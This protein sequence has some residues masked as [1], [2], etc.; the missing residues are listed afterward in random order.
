MLKSVPHPEKVLEKFLPGCATTYQRSKL[1]LAH[2][3][4]T[5]YVASG[6]TDFRSTALEAVAVEAGLPM[7]TFQHTSGP[8]YALVVA[9]RKYSAAVESPHEGHP[10]ATLSRLLS[11]GSQRRDRQFNL[12]RLNDFLSERHASGE[13]DFSMSALVKAWENQSPDRAY[14]AVPRTDYRVLI[15]AWSIYNSPGRA[16]RIKPTLSTVKKSIDLEWA[17][18]KYPHLEEWRALASRWLSTRTSGLGLAISAIRKLFDSYLSAFETA[19][20][21]A[22]LLARGTAIPPIDLSS[23]AAK[24]RKDYLRVHKEFIDW[25]LL[26]QFALEDDFDVPVVSPAFWNPFA[27]AL[28]SSAS[29]PALTESVLSPLAYP[30]IEELRTLLCEGPT[31]KDWKFAQTV[32][33][34]LPGSTGRPGSDWFEVP[35]E[36]IRPDDPD[37]VWRE[38]TLNG[39]QIYEM[40]EPVR[41]VALLVKLIIPLRTMQVR[42]LDSGET[43]ALRFTGDGWEKN[44]HHLAGPNSQGVFQRPNKQDGNSSCVLYVNTNKTADDAEV[45]SAKGYRLPWHQ[46]EEI[47]ENVHYWL[48]KLRDWQEKYNP[49]ERAIPWSELENRHIPAKSDAQLSRFLPTCFLFRSPTD[50]TSPYFPITDS[51]VR[52]AFDYLLHALQQR[53]QKRGEDVT[54][55]WMYSERYPRALFPLHCLRVSLI[56]A[57]VLDGKVPLSIMAK[58]AGHSRMRMTDYYT[59][60]TEGRIQ[61]AIEEATGRLKATREEALQESLLTTRYESLESTFITNTD[62]GLRLALAES[63]SNRNAAG[64]M[65]MH[66]GACLM[67]GNTVGLES[68]PRVGGCHNGGPPFE[69]ARTQGHGPVPGGPRNCIRCRW[70]VTRDVYLPQLV[71]HFNVIAYRYDEAWL[72]AAKHE[73][74]LHALRRERAAAEA[75]SRPFL[76]LSELKAK[77][78]VRE[79]AL[80]TFSDLA[81][82]LVACLQLVERCWNQL[83]GVNAEAE[84]QLIAAGSPQDAKYVI[85]ETASELLQLSGVCEVLEVCED[86]VADAAVLRRSQLINAALE[87]EGAPAALLR[88]TPDEQLKVGNAMMRHLARNANPENEQLGARK[89]IQIMDAGKSLSQHLGVPLASALKL[90]T[91]KTGALTSTSTAA[92]LK[93]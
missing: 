4:L 35:F 63:P 30:Y 89:V 49:V 12:R 46:A 72:K 59:K 3:A 70:F 87:R 14:F 21:P 53:L 61:R 41:W 31:F 25:V 56:T 92:E 36:K 91:E 86:V 84:H 11:D 74:E 42:M 2:A 78:R 10:N 47:Q 22:R 45:G 68:E 7:S 43:D 85:E 19:P 33:G 60:L 28:S 66:H 52:G 64:W 17:R 76:K 20:S 67:G 82:D 6:G 38:R 83:H 65:F 71:N 58:V 15:D 51:K 29:S 73:E 8:I 5:Q 1:Q 50:G 80:K 55:V 26:D 9:H 81:H 93:A 62:S 40:W 24:T 69:G 57:L 44:P 37:C 88:L 75:D 23:L 27:A 77:E 34:A 13:M 90:A 16:P 39:V 32:L 79:G 48:R 54:L 18:L